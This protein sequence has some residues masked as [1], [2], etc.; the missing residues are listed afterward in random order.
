MTPEQ[1]KACNALAIQTQ[2]S[3]EQQSAFKKGFQAAQTPE[4]LLLNPLV[5]EIMFSLMGVLT[6]ATSQ[7]PIYSQE[8]YMKEVARAQKALAPFKR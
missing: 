1:E 5:K 6:C 3:Y 8:V 4:N 7:D 2:W